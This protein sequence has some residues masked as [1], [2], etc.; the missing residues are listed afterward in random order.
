MLCI[1]PV[2]P[3]F[4]GGPCALSA[5]SYV[6]FTLL[7]HDLTILDLSTE[8]SAA[9][10]TKAVQQEVQHVHDLLSLRDLFAERGVSNEELRRYDR[11]IAVARNRLATLARADAVELAA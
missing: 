4:K 7:L 11:A 8:R 6:W 1:R 5:T 2:T 9:M 10:T 3:G